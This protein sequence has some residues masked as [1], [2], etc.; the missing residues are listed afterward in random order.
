MPELDAPKIEPRHRVGCFGEH[1]T[2]FLDTV[3]AN[4]Q[5]EEKTLRYR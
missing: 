1:D 2:D 4:G 3:L 5:D